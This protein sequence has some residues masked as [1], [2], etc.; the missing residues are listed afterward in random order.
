[1]AKK[2]QQAADNAVFEKITQETK[3]LLAKAVPAPDKQLL[4]F[5]EFA[6]ANEQIAQKN[7]KTKD[8][9]TF[10]QEIFSRLVAAGHSQTEAYLK[11]YP[12]CKTSNLNTVYSKA[13]HLAKLDKVG[14]RISALKEKTIKEALMPTTELYQRLT[15]MARNGGKAEIRLKAA[16]LIG[17]IYGVFQPDKETSVI[18]SPSLMLQTVDF[19][20]VASSAD[21][22]A[23]GTAQS[24]EDDK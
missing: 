14:A 23:V 7:P 21:D 19:S 9:L 15:E 13:S 4:L 10:A 24:R 20:K 11:A 5:E 3:N 18:V 6:Q 2:V 22:K 8:G 1:M 12:A 17:K 16:E